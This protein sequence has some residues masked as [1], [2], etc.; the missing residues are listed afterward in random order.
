M[1]TA[2]RQTTR[3]IQIRA[4]ASS[5]T[6]FAD[7]ACRSH[8]LIVE[9]DGATHSTAAELEHDRRRSELLSKLGY[10]VIRIS[11]DEVMNG[12]EEVLVLI[13]ELL[14]SET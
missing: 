8:R 12:M 11:N 2:S 1:G 5:G 9:V 6:I 7:F 14:T 10:R 13:R 3:R 4:P